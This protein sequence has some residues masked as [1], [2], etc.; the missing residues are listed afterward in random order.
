[1]EGRRKKGEGKG[2]G[3][4]EGHYGKVQTKAEDSH[5]PASQHILQAKPGVCLE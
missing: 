2:G 4:G 1:M 3:R 5:N